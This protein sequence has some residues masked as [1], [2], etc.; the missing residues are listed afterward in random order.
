MVRAS[1]SISAVGMLTRQLVADGAGHW[2]V[3]R[4]VAID[5]RLHLHR[6]DL[7]NR[8]LRPDIAVAC[9]AGD[10]F[11]RM[12]AVAE[13]HEIGQAVDRRRRR[14]YGLGQR[15]SAMARLAGLTGREPS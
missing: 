9:L 13:H 2:S 11:C 6:E 5:A 7:F 4:L 12:A 3:L 10:S 8:I 1:E 14:Q 15:Y